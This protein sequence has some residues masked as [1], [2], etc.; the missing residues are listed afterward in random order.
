MLR[1]GLF[2]LLPI[3]GAIGERIHAIQ[4]R[5]DPKVAAA[6]RPH[7]TL[8]GSSGVGPILPGPSVAELRAALSPVSETTPPL[9]L[10]FGRPH[11]YM[12]TDII[13]LP[14]DSHGPLRT[15]HERIARSG[16]RFA[17]SRFPFSPHA[18]LSLYR[19]L[20]PESERALMSVRID[21]PFVADRIQVWKTNEPQPAKLLV[22]LELTGGKGLAQRPA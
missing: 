5:F 17:P 14:L 7:V 3:G 15:L 10:H 4:L 20:T 2:V 6:Q 13:V 9:T 12:Q 21:E 18:T 8:A 19:Q 11:R 16:L 22:E 1:T